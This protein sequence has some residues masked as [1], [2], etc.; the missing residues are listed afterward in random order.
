MTG[1]CMAGAEGAGAAWDDDEVAGA[2]AVVAAF[3]AQAPADNSTLRPAMIPPRN[4]KLIG[5]PF[6]TSGFVE[7]F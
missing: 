4:F 2:A 3:C 7:L 6:A 5:T 1:A